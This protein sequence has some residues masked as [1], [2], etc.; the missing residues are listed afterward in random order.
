MFSHR[1]AISYISPKLTWF[2]AR[3]QLLEA[4][5]KQRTGIIALRRSE[6]Y[7]VLLDNPLNKSPTNLEREFLVSLLSGRN[8]TQL[9]NAT[10]VIA[11]NESLVRSEQVQFS[12]SD[13]YL[14]SGDLVNTY[15]A[16]DLQYK[17]RCSHVGCHL[18]TTKQHSIMMCDHQHHV[19]CRMHILDKV[20]DEVT[21]EPSTRVMNVIDQVVHDPELA[22]MAGGAAWTSPDI[23]TRLLLACQEYLASPSR[24]KATPE[25]FVNSRYVLD[26]K[27]DFISCSVC[28]HV[29]KGDETRTSF[30]HQQLF[31]QQGNPL[32]PSQSPSAAASSQGTVQESSI[33]EQLLDNLHSHFAILRPN[34][35]VTLLDEG[36]SPLELARTVQGFDV[37]RCKG[38]SLALLREDMNRTRR[39][40]Q[41]AAVSGVPQSRTSPRDLTNEQPQAPSRLDFMTNDLHSD[42]SSRASPKKSNQS[43]GSTGY[44]NS[45]KDIADAFKRI[46]PSFCGPLYNMGFSDEEVDAVLSELPKSDWVN[47]TTLTMTRLLYQYRARNNRQ[48]SDVTATPESVSRRS[49]G[50]DTYGV[51]S[52]QGY[53]VKSEI[54]PHVHSPNRS[55]TVSRFEREFP[56]VYELLCIRK[57]QDDEIERALMEVAFNNYSHHDDLIAVMERNRRSSARYLTEHLAS[58]DDRYSK[59]STGNSCSDSERKLQQ[60]QH[61]R[62]YDYDFLLSSGFMRDEISAALDLMDADEIA[63][64]TRDHLQALISATKESMKPSALGA[65]NCSEAKEL[66]TSS[67]AHP[68]PTQKPQPSELPR[69]Q[70]EYHNTLASNGT[71]SVRLLCQETGQ[72]VEVSVYKDTPLR[73]VDLAKQALNSF[74]SLGFST[75][76]ITLYRQLP[77]TSTPRQSSS[78]GDVQDLGDGWNEDI[79]QQA[80][81]SGGYLRLQGGDLLTVW[82]V[83][84]AAVG[85][86][87]LMEVAI[88]TDRF[89]AALVQKLRMLQELY[90]GFRKIRG[91]GNCYYRAFIFGLLESIVVS[92]DRSAYSHL[93]RKLRACYERYAGLMKA[94]LSLQDTMTNNYLRETLSS[95]TRA[96]D[97]VLT[98]LDRAS[99][100]LIWATVSDLEHSMLRTDHVESIT[101]DTALIL[102][103]KCLVAEYLESNQDLEM[104]GLPLRDAILLFHEELNGSMTAYCQQYVTKLGVDAEGAFL[105]LEI[106]PRSLNCKCNIIYLDRLESSGLK[107]F[108][109]DDPPPGQ[110]T[111]SGSATDLL[112]EVHLLLRP[113]HYDLLYVRTA[114]DTNCGSS[115]TDGS[116]PTKL[117]G[118]QAANTATPAVGN[119]LDLQE[120]ASLDMDTQALDM[121]YEIINHEDVQTSDAI[122]KDVTG[123]K[124]SD[125][126]QLKTPATSSKLAPSSPSFKDKTAAD[127]AP[128]ESWTPDERLLCEIL[129]LTPRR[130][131]QLLATHGSVDEA[132]AVTLDDSESQ[133]SG[134]YDRN[135]GVAVES[136]SK[137][138][139]SAAVSTSDANVKV[140][141]TSWVVVASGEGYANWLDTAGN[142]MFHLRRR[143]VGGN[144]EVVMNT[145]L[146]RQWLVAYKIPLSVAN[147]FQN[148]TLIISVDVHPSLGYY[149]T[150]AGKRYLYSHQI[151]WPRFSGKVVLSIGWLAS[152][153]QRAN[154]DVSVDNKGLLGES[155]GDANAPKAIDPKPTAGSGSPPPKP[156]RQMV[157]IVSISPN[158]QQVIDVLGVS[159]EE[160]KQLI[161]KYITVEL[162]VESVFLGQE[163]AVSKKKCEELRVH[164]HQYDAAAPFSSRITRDNVESKVESR[165]TGAQIKDSRLLEPQRNLNSHVPAGPGR[166]PPQN[167]HYSDN[168][169]ARSVRNAEAED[170]SL[171]K[172]YYKIHF[173]LKEA[174]CQEAVEKLVGMGYTELQAVQA[175]VDTNYSTDMSRLFQH[176]KLAMQSEARPPAPPTSSSYIGSNSYAAAVSLGGRSGS[177]VVSPSTK[178]Y[179]DQTLGTSASRTTQ[180]GTSKEHLSDAK[181]RNVLTYSKS[182]VDSLSCKDTHI[183]L[184]LLGVPREMWPYDASGCRQLLYNVIQ[185]CRRREHTTTNR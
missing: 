116:D 64:T 128:G 173:R 88:N 32:N 75:G 26:V 166:L 4:S 137:A 101:L 153:T 96:V 140:E 12:Q 121:T 125:I 124:Q 1:V 152:T 20:I 90:S 106:L 136:P 53:G 123:P 82:R 130:A 115:S 119:K 45:A 72:A 59:D 148:Q 27:R 93:Y 143:C 145:C 44:A 129:D 147:A 67:D 132:L 118:M 70:H 104:N 161:H 114:K 98:A 39:R 8:D 68:A 24:L 181:R 7:V 37:T 113:G 112:I 150:I 107:V 58:T 139:S 111:D 164:E 92:G 9:F 15:L 144:D 178:E 76:D 138:S 49:G 185:E 100:G 83:Q 63:H 33:D 157:P 55:N 56:R 131:R 3:R 40:Q 29:R 81:D 184:Q 183:Y 36:Y 84:G 28:S 176:P 46:R 85:P 35:Y 135:S 163:L 169:N 22:V 71:Y 47:V 99:Q 109:R 5:T 51:T 23:R 10:H 16:A 78:V 177:T 105:E 180:V 66:S 74:P 38:I 50:V 146:A 60:F 103:C 168:F 154:S 149:V 54:V 117:R 13:A 134:S 167:D 30:F 62:Y 77:G 156:Q 2:S 174:D 25:S 14:G 170:E 126:L 42:N 86:K 17:V 79:Q 34:D 80:Y 69:S 122:A 61:R 182:K 120:G 73:Y 151:D 21:S 89:N 160:A 6:Y 127:L 102:S 175:L 95:I 91:D 31:P 165:L 87:V 171:L 155:Y 97:I 11:I 43:S 162:A 142:I 41:D 133:A 18:L 158:E 108:A 65:N 141:D 159:V 110:L 172:H 179:Y 52:D 57:Y 19:I 48:L 94:K